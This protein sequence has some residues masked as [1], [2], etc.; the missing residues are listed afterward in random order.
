MAAKESGNSQNTRETNDGSFQ[1]Q[2]KEFGFT[3]YFKVSGTVNIAAE[4]HQYHVH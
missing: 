2:S 4:S 3:I 1:I